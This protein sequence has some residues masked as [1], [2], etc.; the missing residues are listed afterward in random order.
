MNRVLSLPHATIF[1]G[2]LET[3]KKERRLTVVTEEGTIRLNH[4]LGPVEM[5]F[6]TPE[7]QLEAGTKVYV[8]WKGGGFVCAPVKEVSAE[9]RQEKRKRRNRIEMA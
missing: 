5:K 3:M 1:P 8:W 9:K 4:Y 2:F 7:H 6:S